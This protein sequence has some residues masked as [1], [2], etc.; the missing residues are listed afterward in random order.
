MVRNGTWILVSITL[1]AAACSR[2]SARGREYKL[3]G[4]VLAVDQA[5][6]EITIKHG[7]IA[8]FMPG[9]TMAFRVTDGK[10]LTGR[11]PG[12]VVSATLVVEGSNA[13]LRTLDGTGHVPVSQPA[14]LPEAGL[15][16]SGQPAADAVLIDET[17]AP[18]RLADSHGNVVA[19]TFMYTRCPLPNYCP[20]M[21]RQFKA[22]QESV[23]ADPGLNSRVRLL[24]VSLDP[25][26]DTPAVLA[27]HAAE[28]QADP[29]IWHFA[30]G[31]PDDLEKF[32]S[33]FGVSVMREESE[34]VHNLR[35]AV[36]DG[37]GRL[38][39]IFN[40]SDWMPS[41][42]ITELRTAR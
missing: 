10:L 30:T 39:K 20:L 36:I 33:Q 2:P 22:V 19:V 32:G 13:H 35:T 24:S 29:S 41:D 5:R 16:S 6:Q 23:R 1:A 38:V 14:T 40:G 3:S 28:L 26:H 12:D 9:M 17:G 7:D 4:Q 31:A 18:W 25:G 42:L 34:V 27:K 11:V 37:Q 21:D 15:L 8:G